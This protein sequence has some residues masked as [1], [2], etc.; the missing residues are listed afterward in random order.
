M[1]AGLLGGLFIGVMGNLDGI[2]QVLQ[3]VWYK[4]SNM[5]DGFPAFDFWRSSRMIPDM[6]NFDP[7]PALCWVPGK[8]ADTPDMSP[9]ITEFPFFTF[10]FADLHAHMMAIPFTLLVIGLGLNIVVGLRREG[11]SC[12][13]APGCC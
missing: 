1:G 13:S 8:I 4:A 10:L 7:L 9:H 3:G 12:A 2:V 6:E 5:N 11:N